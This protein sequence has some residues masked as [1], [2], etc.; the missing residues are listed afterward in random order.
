M[1]GEKYGKLINFKPFI[2]SDLKGNKNEKCVKQI[3]GITDE[4]GLRLAYEAKYGLHQPY[5]TLFIAG[6]KDFPVAHTDDLK[7]SFDD[8]LNKTKRG[9]DA[10]AYC[11]PHHELDTV[12][13]HS[14]GG[15]VSLALETYKKD[16]GTPM[17]FFNLKHLELQ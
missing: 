14:L 15:S 4:E 6:A 13:S 9:R 17:V 3:A 8:T 16:N 11:R 1:L 7:L 2:D 5:N 12:I 10:D